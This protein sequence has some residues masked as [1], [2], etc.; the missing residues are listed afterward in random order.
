MHE[1]FSLLLTNAHGDH[2]RTVLV[3]MLTEANK[4]NEVNMQMQS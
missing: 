1:L 2:N 4:L 3:R